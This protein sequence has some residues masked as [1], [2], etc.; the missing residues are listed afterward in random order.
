MFASGYDFK[1]TAALT[2]TLIAFDK[3]IGLNK[4]VCLHLN[5]S[6]TVL[7]S[8][9][10]RHADIGFGEIGLPAFKL[11]IKN[12]KLKHLDALLETPT[13]N[14]NYSKQ[15]LKLKKLQK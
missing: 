11:L 3:H 12:Q 7:N 14:E 15:I 4:L 1:T 8:H 9:R 10:D 2:K 6:L 5:D 13:S